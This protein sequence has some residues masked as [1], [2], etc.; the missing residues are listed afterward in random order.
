MMSDSPPREPR[1]SVIL[2]AR[3]EHGE[4]S[5][6]VRVRNLSATGAC[7]DNP[8]ELQKGNRIGVTMGSLV[9]LSA[10]VMWTSP[11]LAGLHFSDGVID[12]AEAR[13][14][15]ERGTAGTKASAG[16]INNVQHAYRRRDT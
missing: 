8:G 9:A 4:R 15:R 14:P 2:Y 3:I 11:T 13:R 6:E 12:L 16:W 7:V 10:E 1:S 5:V